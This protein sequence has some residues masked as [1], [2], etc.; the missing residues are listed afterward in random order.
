MIASTAEFRKGL[1]ILIDDEPFVIV[2][3]QHVKPGKGGAFVKTRIKS[4]VT[5]NVLDRTFRSGD[6]AEIPDVEQREMQYL[7]KEEDRYYFMDI[8]TYDQ[9]FVP[10]T[11]LGDAVNYLKDGIV[12]ALS[13]YRGK[14][15]GV[16]LPNFV[17]LKVMKTE[18]GMK[19]DTAQNA[20]KP[21]VLES[22]YTLQVPLFLEEGEVVKIDTRTGQYMTRVT[23]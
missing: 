21:A 18:P 4:L 3:F 9:L 11:N 1:K 23:R 13:F 2:E 10:E 6:K 12:I 17:D 14:A 8:S 19:G 5:G 15:I 16:E 22:G 7:Y 20:T